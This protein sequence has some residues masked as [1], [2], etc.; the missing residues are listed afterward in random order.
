LT[1]LD[2][3]AVKASDAPTNMTTSATLTIAERPRDKTLPMP[4]PL[5]MRVE[6][7]PTSQCPA[8]AQYE[9]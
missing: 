4:S 2:V 7:D 5:P 9:Q 8:R 1:A 3:D 6:N